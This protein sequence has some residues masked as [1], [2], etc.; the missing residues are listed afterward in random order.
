MGIGHAMAIDLGR[1]RFRALQCSGGQ[2]IR[3]KRTFI[4]DYPAEM[5]SDDAQALGQW[6]GQ[7]LKAA[8]FPKGK[9]VIAIGR[10]HVGVKRMSLPTTVEDELPDM[11]R[12][13]MQRE[14]PFD[15]DA[16]VID[17]VPVDRDH[18]STTVL[19]VAVPRTMV[20]FAE[21]VARSAGYGVERISLRTMGAAALLNSMPR[22][23]EANAHGIL[24]ID[25]T[26]EGVEFCLVSNGSIR[27]SRAAEVPQPGDRL[28]IADAVVTETRRTW[29]SYRIGDA[30]PEIQHAIIMGDQRVSAYAAGPLSEMLKI[31]V[32]VLH[33]H[34]RVESAGSDEFDPIWP[35]AGLLLESSSTRSAQLIDFAHPRQAPDLSARTRIRRMLA[36][37]AILLIA[38]LCW[39]LARS[40]LNSLQSKVDSLKKQQSDE[41]PAYFKYR[42]AVYKVE[43]LRRWQSLTAD[44][45]NHAAHL[46][47]MA[48][49]ADRVVLD[50]WTGILEAGDVKFDKVSSKW[51]SAQQ[52]TIVIDGEAKDRQTAD[53]FREA[54]VQTTLYTTNTPGSEAAGGKRLPFGFTYRLRTRE[55]SPLETE[56]HLAVP[57]N[58]TPTA[59]PPEK[60]SA[61]QLAASEGVK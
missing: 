56:S 36:A 60:S 8:G 9:A 13:A 49:P 10:E 48:P 32:A 19:A 23:A 15:A 25:I 20:E 17:F 43:H 1:R 42:R 58:A 55:G 59:N 18:I 57:S 37:A 51:S 52:V 21:T 46:A 61:E 34:P 24:G 6:I 54:L 40:D 44:W 45:L 27:F 16:A 41:S 3:I 47:S 31:P 14:L 2:V 12:L 29:M 50:S 53:A 35:L 30:A 38:G 11:T 39:T 4:K 22:D 33:R 28:A 5:K 7:Q 26:G